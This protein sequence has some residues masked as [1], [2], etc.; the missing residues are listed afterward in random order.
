MNGITYSIAKTRRYS[1]PTSQE[2]ASITWLVNFRWYLSC[3][4]AMSLEEIVARVQLALKKK[5][6][7]RR[8]SWVAPKPIG[9]DA[10]DEVGEV[11]CPQSSVGFDD[12]GIFIRFCPDNNAN[13]CK[14]LFEFV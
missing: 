1:V 13:L 4:R 3:L 9:I 14:K 2:E 6:W 8:V 5:I 7:Q 11:E 10:E 12:A